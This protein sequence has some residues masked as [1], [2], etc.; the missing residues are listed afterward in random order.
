MSG[1]VKGLVKR[2]SIHVMKY[3]ISALRVPDMRPAPLS[4]EN[5]CAD[6][7]PGLL[8]TPLSAVISRTNEV[9]EPMT[10]L[11]IGRVR[12]TMLN[13]NSMLGFLLTVYH[14]SRVVG[15]IFFYCMKCVAYGRV[16]IYS[17]TYNLLASPLVRFKY[18]GSRGSIPYLRHNSSPFFCC[19]SI[20]RLCAG[21]LLFSLRPSWRR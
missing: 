10:W 5:D 16:A 1:R 12:Y 2:S 14:H 15:S 3:A 21:P 9:P 7:N 4:R 17:P 13:L 20:L 6:H 18:K 19:A 8:P 11:C